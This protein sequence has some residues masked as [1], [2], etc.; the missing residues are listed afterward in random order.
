MRFLRWYFATSLLVALALPIIA[1]V[2]G[3]LGGTSATDAA[4]IILGYELWWAILFWTPLTAISLVVCFLLW[5]TGFLP[6]VERTR[7]G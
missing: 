3:A 4:V 1:L 6:W 7:S 5:A 2:A